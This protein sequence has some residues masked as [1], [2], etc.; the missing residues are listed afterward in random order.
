[1]LNKLTTKWSFDLGG[2]GLNLEILISKGVLHL[3]T[4]G[5]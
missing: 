2:F 3:E 1:M 4:L 5:H